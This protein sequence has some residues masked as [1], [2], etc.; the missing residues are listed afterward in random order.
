MEGVWLICTSKMWAGTQRSFRRWRIR[1]RGEVAAHGGQQSAGA[2]EQLLGPGGNVPGLPP[3]AI[4]PASCAR[5]SRRA[6]PC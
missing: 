3:Q 5:G 2:V 1:A 4:W 6:S